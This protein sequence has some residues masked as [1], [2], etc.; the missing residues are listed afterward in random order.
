[1]Y[2]NYLPLLFSALAFSVSAAETTA[3][4]ADLEPMTNRSFS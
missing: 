4:D 2:A 3:F 1:M